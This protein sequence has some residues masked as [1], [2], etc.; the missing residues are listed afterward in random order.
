MLGTLKV[1]NMVPGLPAPSLVPSISCVS[2]WLAGLR[3]SW[4]R[5]LFVLV[6]PQTV[7][8]EQGRDN[9]EAREEC[10]LLQAVVPELL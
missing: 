1:V 8:P 3:P 4:L 6:I 7:W 2:A 9:A 10:A 5:G